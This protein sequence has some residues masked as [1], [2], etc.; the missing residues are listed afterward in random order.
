[1]TLPLNSSHRFTWCP[2]ESSVA[3]AGLDCDPST[4]PIS[5]TS[6][7]PAR[8]ASSPWRPL[9]GLISSG[10]PVVSA[11]ALWCL[12]SSVLVAAFGLLVPSHPPRFLLPASWMQTTGVLLLDVQRC[13]PVGVRMPAQNG[14]GA[15]GLLYLTALGLR[16]LS[17]HE[18]PVPVAYALARLGHL[19]T[20][21]STGDL[22]VL[23]AITVS[24]RV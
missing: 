11:A 10:G 23:V 15:W 19:N 16:R 4:P 21:L 8:P 2:V 18:P 22:R 9:G 13:S 7:T 20:E 1:M 14:R 24:L 3:G 5:S 17:P 6:S 12:A